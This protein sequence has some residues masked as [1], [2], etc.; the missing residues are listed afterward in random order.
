M[1]GSAAQPLPSRAVISISILA[2]SIRVGFLFGGGGE[3]PNALP[4]NQDTKHDQLDMIELALDPETGSV[5]FWS[6][7]DNIHDIHYVNAVPESGFLTREEA[8][9]TA[10]EWI[11]S[12]SKVKLD[13]SY[14]K[15][16]VYFIGPSQNTEIQIKEWRIDFWGDEYEYSVYLDAKSG[17]VTYYRFDTFVVSADRR[18]RSP[19]SVDT[20]KTVF[21]GKARIYRCEVLH[22]ERIIGTTDA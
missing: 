15:E 13:S 6:Y 19:N 16:A 1:S 17:E 8:V 4:V 5:I 11:N 9:E 18:T 14:G 12:Q 10:V 20:I 22:N 2:A 3:I 21:P 7:L